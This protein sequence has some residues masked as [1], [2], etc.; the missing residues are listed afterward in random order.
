[1][2]DYSKY[3]VETQYA[4]FVRDDTSPALA[5]IAGLPQFMFGTSDY[6]LD[7]EAAL[8]TGNGQDTF[9]VDYVTTAS[10]PVIF[11][12]GG[13]DMIWGGASVDAVVIYGQAGDDF[14][15]GG[16]GADKL[17][18][19][20]GNDYLYGDMF[21]FL[22]DIEQ[23]YESNDQIWGEEGDDWIAAGIGNDLVYGGADNDTIA[24]DKGDDKLYGNS[25]D[26][27]IFGDYAVYLDY[28]DYYENAPY[29][30][31]EADYGETDNDQIWGGRSRHY[32]WP[33]GR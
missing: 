25:G 18:G 22:Y 27:L 6:W 12:G 20:T 13:N 5:V 19:G 33:V 8:H 15:E 9:A 17:F 11:A 23:S 24:G 29:E 28:E 10:A 1:M 4:T 3:T 31:W 7:S 30:G 32:L 21:E 2:T 14:I 26:D 16:A